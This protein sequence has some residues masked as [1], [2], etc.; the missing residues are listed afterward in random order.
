MLLSS[1]SPTRSV[2]MTKATPTASAFRWI[3]ASAIAFISL[4]PRAELTA[5]TRPAT[6]AASG[7][8]TLKGMVIDSLHDGPLAKARVMIEGTERS[9]VTDIDGRY[10]I[11]SIPPGQHRVVV[12]HPLLDTL[13]ITIR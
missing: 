11:D 2:D 10:R 8:T 12:L 13:G 7:F 1:P 9:A 4:A 5:Q 3:A 6:P